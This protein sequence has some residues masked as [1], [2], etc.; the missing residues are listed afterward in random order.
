MRN[1]DLGF[2]VNIRNRILYYCILKARE[3]LVIL[4][5][6]WPLH[7]INLTNNETALYSLNSKKLY[8]DIVII[9]A[10]KLLQITVIINKKKMLF[11][12]CDPD[13]CWSNKGFGA[14]S[15]EF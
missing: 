5:I 8:T 7:L 15:S 10:D 9:S 1:F 2:Q 12:P 6:I 3:C 14:S 11:T 4:L 13:T